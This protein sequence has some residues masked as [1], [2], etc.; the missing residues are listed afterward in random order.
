MDGQ[1]SGGASLRGRGRPT[2]LPDTV[3]VKA[4]GGTRD[5]IEKAAVADGMAA[6]DWLRR[7]IRRG[8]EASRKRRERRGG[9]HEL[10][11]GKRRTQ[12]PG[13]DGA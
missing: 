6:P 10:A 13:S 3:T 12:L 7:L 9:D 4:P 8:I 5:A 11:R 2:R 1:Q